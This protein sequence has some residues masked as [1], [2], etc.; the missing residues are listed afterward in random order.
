MDLDRDQLVGG[1]LAGEALWRRP[2][3]VREHGRAD[4]AG[5]H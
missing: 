2:S 5:V 4:S 1:D 3:G